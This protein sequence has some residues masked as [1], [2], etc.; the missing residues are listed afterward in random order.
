MEIQKLAIANDAAC[1]CL[2]HTHMKATSF[3]ATTLT[4]QCHSLGFLFQKAVRIFSW[5][6]KNASETWTCCMPVSRLLAHTRLTYPPVLWKRPKT[7]VS[8]GTWV[9]T[10]PLYAAWRPE[11]ALPTL[12]VV[13]LRSLHSN[14]KD[15]LCRDQTFTSTPF[16]W[17]YS[18]ENHLARPHGYQKWPHLPVMVSVCLSLFRTHTKWPFFDKHFLLWV[19]KLWYLGPK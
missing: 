9:Q 3:A 12:C 16:F 17:L 11:R 18:I 5:R 7:S 2:L 6:I 15:R 8:R 1:P 14:T 19:T 13:P 4:L 10:G